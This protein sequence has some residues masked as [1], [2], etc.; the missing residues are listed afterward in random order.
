M[1]T[2]L[3]RLDDRMTRRMVMLC[4]VPIRRIVAASDVT[5]DLAQTKMQPTRSDLQTI[6]ASLRARSNDT[7]LAQVFTAFHIGL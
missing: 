7:Y 5:A 6:L 1:F 3:E 2:G 4:R